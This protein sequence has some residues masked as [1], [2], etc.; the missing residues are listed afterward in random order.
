MRFSQRLLGKHESYLNL[1]SKLGGG[2]KIRKFFS[3]FSVYS[4]HVGKAQKQNASSIGWCS[5]RAGVIEVLAIS[6]SSILQWLV[7]FWY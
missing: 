1:M 4:T 7:W 6:R 5:G 3:V 2:G